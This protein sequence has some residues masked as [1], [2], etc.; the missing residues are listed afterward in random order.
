MN[1]KTSLSAIAAITGLTAGSALAADFTIDTYGDYGNTYLEAYSKD[2]SKKHGVEFE[3]VT[4]NWNDHHNKLATNLATGEGAGDLVFVDTGMIGNFVS[5]GG[6]LDLTDKMKSLGVDFAD[7]AVSQGKGNDGRQYGVPVDLGPGVMYYRRDYM[8][9]MGYDLSAVFRD[10]D[11]YLEYGREL[12]KKDILLVGN[13]SD[14]AQAIIYFTVEEG[15][16]IYTDA[17]GKSLITSE[18]FVRA[19]EIAKTIRDEG[20]DGNIAAWTNDWYE[21]FKQGKFATQMS[22]AWLLG[23]LNNWIAPDTKGKWGAANLPEGIYGSWGGSFLAIPKQ[24]KNPE[25]AWEM[26]KYMTTEGQQIE[27]FKKIAAFPANSATYDDPSFAEPIEFLNGQKARLLFADIA[28]KIKPVL[29]GKADHIA[30]SLVIQTA[31]QEVLDNGR[32]IK[33]ALKAAEKQLKRRMRSL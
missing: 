9:D 25:A 5:Q 16:G 15:N 28:S 33:E 4:N 24:S 6:F 29:P 22:G 20:M 14:V 2:F 30:D 18:R 3:F 1:L 13:A 19:F 31:L 32:P 27:G 8:E 21:G 10:F 17:K 23:H 11:S 12:K 26:I 7:F